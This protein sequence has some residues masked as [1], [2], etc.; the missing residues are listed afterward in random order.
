MRRRDFLRGAAGAALLGAAGNSGCGRDES[1]NQE[2][3][4]SNGLAGRRFLTFNSVIR[5]NQIEVTRTRNEG[6]DEYDRHTPENVQALRR[7]LAEGWP[8]APMTWAFSWRALHDERERYATLRRLVAEFHHRYGDDVTFIPGAFF[9][10]AYNTREQV[11]RDLH[12]GLARVSEIMGGGFRPKSLIAGF[13]AADNQ[14]YL[15]QEEGIHVCQGNIWSQYAVDNQDGEG[16]ICYPYYPSREHF[17]KPAQ[18][19]AD[20]VDCVNLDGWTMDFL[21][22]RRPGGQ[23]SRRNRQYSRMGVGPIETIGQFG[24]ETGLQQMLATT[25]AHFDTGFDLNGWAWVTN[26]WEISL[27]PQVGHLEILTAWVRAI[28]ERWPSAECLTLGDFG[29]IWRQEH[30][31]NDDIDYRF[32]QRGTGIGGSDAE[33]E[34]RWF[35]NKQFRLALLRDWRRDEPEEVIDFTRYDLPAQ[36]PQELT[37]NWSLMNRLNQKG[38]RPQDRPA[39]FAELPEEDRRIIRG[40]YPDLG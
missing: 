20:H 14:Q 33:L 29:Q 11:N 38:I 21:A 32:R 7:A 34:I 37:R 36:E 9:P 2:E 3:A 1:A 35:M 18:S 22:A 13:L 39:A 4:S 17:C 28:R 27:V 31:T 30:R 12:E 24:P 16:S 40:R 8:G 15:A 19:R 26:C 25:A 23:E 6:F 10:N 5:V